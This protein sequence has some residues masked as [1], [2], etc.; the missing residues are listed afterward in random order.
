MF[1]RISVKVILIAAVLVVG[2]L[3]LNQNV[4]VD[5][6]DLEGAIDRAGLLGPIVYVVIL[7]LGLTIPFNPVSDILT[8]TVAAIV[9]D[10][11]VAILATFIVHTIA[12]TVNYTIGYFYGTRLMD[13]VLERRDIPLLRRVRDGIT[14][15]AIF[16]LRF[17]LPLTAIGVDWISYL[18][19][20]Q[21]L[22]FSTYFVASMV[23]W[24]L[25]SVIY[26]SSAALLRETSPFLVLVPAVV[27]ITGAS[28]LLLVLRRRTNI[29]DAPVT[30]SVTE[31]PTHR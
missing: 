29:L 18:A 23:P 12:V 11:K 24:T 27:L 13:R 8:I 9:L 15:R 4:E 31:A 25:M 2:L 21:R 19:G 5:E 3:L 10:P 16:L 28:L 22:R 14:V 20:A 26:F 1:S 7:T 17:A 30:E 6:D